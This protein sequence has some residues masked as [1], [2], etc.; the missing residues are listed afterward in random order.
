MSNFGWH[1]PPG[2]SQRMIDERY[3]ESD[4]L[5]CPKHDEEYDIEDGCPGCEEEELDGA[6]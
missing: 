6:E 3:A 2:V 1:L 4:P 5:W